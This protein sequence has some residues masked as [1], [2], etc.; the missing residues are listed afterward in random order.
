MSDEPWTPLRFCILLRLAGALR[1]LACR[2]PASAQPPFVFIIFS[3]IHDIFVSSSLM[4]SKVAVEGAIVVA[5]GYNEEDV[6]LVSV[7][8]VDVHSGS[9]CFLASIPTAREVTIF[10]GQARTFVSFTFHG[11]VALRST[12]HCWLRCWRHVLDGR[13][14]GRIF[15]AELSIAVQL[16]L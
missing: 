15:G 5:G 8:R 11:H 12:V 9:S 6:L 7:E 16:G 2:S 13:R 14:L 10:A 4:R 3:F 1:R